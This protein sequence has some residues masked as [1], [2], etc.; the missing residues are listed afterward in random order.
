MKELGEYLKETRMLNGVG[1]EEAANDLKLELSD[2]DN[3]EAGNTRAFND[4]LSLKNTIEVYS[5]YLGLDYDKIIDEYND[6]IFEHTS[7]ISLEDI[8]EAQKQSPE[9]PKVASPYTR[10]LK[11]KFCFDNFCFRPSAKL[12]PYLIGILIVCAILTVIIIYMIKIEGSRTVITTELSGK[13][14]ELYELTK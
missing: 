10:P 4:I 1:L 7:K 6:F 12:K 13:K 14:S 8:I 2:L 9:G 11:R 5:K 3:L